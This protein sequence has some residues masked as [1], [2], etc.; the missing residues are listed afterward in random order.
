MAGP[1]VYFLEPHQDDAALFMAQ[2]IAHHVLAGREVHVVL[3]SNGST[4][5]V[6]GELNGTAADPTWWAGTHDPAAEGYAPMTAAEFGLAR[7]REWRQSA[8]HLG[9]PPAQQHLGMDVA[10]S[11]L[12]P[13]GITQAY[14]TDVMQYWLD[15]DLNAGLARP[16]FYTMWW[17]DPTA[18][19]AACGQALR[20]LRLSDPDF[21]DSRWMVKPEQ[22]A[23]AS[24]SVY[25]VPAA[26]VAEVKLM[27]KRAAW[28][29][30]AWAPEQ[31]AFAV[32][33]HS[34]RSY[35]EG[36]PLVGAV[37]HIVRNP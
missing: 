1:R 25:G 9:V 8:R 29:Y 26:L 34:V 24:A 20:A 28:A 12:L 10:T 6:L 31:G 23:A 30:G 27:Q 35:F 32:G 18:D 15:H 2:A 3:M 14:A 19:H 16:G 36:G 4:S 37:N 21:A 5:Q 11:D 33:M 22:A 7:T 17:G 13:N